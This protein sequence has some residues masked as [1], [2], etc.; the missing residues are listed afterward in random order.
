MIQ[1]KSLRII[2]QERVDRQ[3]LFGLIGPPPIDSK[4]AFTRILIPNIN[5]VL[6]EVINLRDILTSNSLK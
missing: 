1:T 4:I 6:D 3:R 2:R 5:H